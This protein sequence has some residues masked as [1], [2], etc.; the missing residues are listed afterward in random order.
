MVLDH[1]HLYGCDNMWQGIIVMPGATLNIN[2]GTLIEDALTAVDITNSTAS[3]NL[4]NVNGAIFNKNQTAININNYATTASPYPFNIKDAVFTWRDFSSNPWPTT[5][6]LKTISGGATISEHYSVGD[7]PTIGFIPNN[8]PNCIGGPCPPKK[9]I[10]LNGVGNLSGTTYSDI[11]IGGGLSNTDLNVF[12]N[13]A[14]GIY[15]LNSNLTCYNNAFQYILTP[16][17]HN[18][19]GTAIVATSDLSAKNR[20]QVMSDLTNG[21]GPNS[22]YNCSR[23]VDVESY[24]NITVN[25]CEIRS[26][27]ETTSPQLRQGE[28]GI[29]IKT[30]YCEQITADANTIS[31]I[32]NGIVFIADVFTSGT[33]NIQDLGSIAITNNTIQATLPGL[34]PTDEYAV[35][36]IVANNV[37]N[38]S[39]NVSLGGHSPMALVNVS[40]NHLHDVHNGIYMNNWVNYQFSSNYGIGNVPY[41][42]NNFV[43]LRQFIYPDNIP[44]IQYGIYNSL[45]WNTN[46]INNNVVGF[47]NVFDYWV[48]IASHDNIKLSYERVECNQATNN[49]IG[50]SFKGNYQQGT[51]FANN[52]MESSGKGFV[53]DNAAIGDQGDALASSDNQWTG[54]Y[55]PSQFTTYTIGG[56]DPLQSRLFV[57]QGS[58]TFDPSIAGTCAGIPITNFYSFGNGLEPAAPGSVNCGT[59]PLQLTGTGNNSGQQKSMQTIDGI[60]I[61]RLEQLV[62]DSITYSYFA[63]EQHINDKFTVYR[64]LN[65]KP[66]LKD[67]SVILQ[68]FYNYALNNNLGKLANAENSLAGGQL[69]DAQAYINSVVADNS[70]ETNYVNYFTAYLHYKNNTYTVADSASLKTLAMGCPVRDGMVV[71][72]ARSLYSLIYTDFRVYSDNCIDNTKRETTSIKK[73]T[74]INSLEV[75][76]NPNNGTFKV[77]LAG[78]KIADG[79]V[80]IIISDITGKVVFNSKIQIKDNDAIFDKDLGNGMYL[81]SVKNSDGYLYSPKKIIVIK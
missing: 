41:C 73:V 36:G 57:Q 54:T 72:Q 78:D 68:N 26:N 63:D 38:Y 58:S 21:N 20:L 16:I 19:G 74:F 71:Y 76:P 23:S 69:N 39:G 44:Q 32:Q 56:S 75:Y 14:F 61:N 29:Y 34:T 5:A 62:T 67:S 33:Y 53:L 31:N 7:L 27:A 77:K 13:L 49:G 80:E 30:F 6:S 81:I 48:G 10:N 12:D 28:M 1:C 17:V 35:T 65:T 3:A 9:G 22:F 70:I 37:M 45:N 51:R 2:N 60:D 79:S 59:L 18:P 64:M 52:L 11:V 40:N 15:A 42:D 47:G 24:V 25:D 4:L 8:M 50:I 46:I 55:T 66:E 43:S